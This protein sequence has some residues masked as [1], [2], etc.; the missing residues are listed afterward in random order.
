[1]EETRSDDSVGGGRWVSIFLGGERDVF[2]AAGWE[3]M[4]SGRWEVEAAGSDADE[5]FGEV[6]RPASNSPAH[7]NAPPP[8]PC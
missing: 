5:D 4:R 6:H 1:M 2:L 3:A 8:A 7:L